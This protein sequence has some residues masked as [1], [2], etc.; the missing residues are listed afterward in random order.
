MP[1]FVVAAIIADAE[2]RL[3]VGQRPP[4]KKLAGYWEFPGGKVEA[5]ETPEMAVIRELKEELGITVEPVRRL[6][7]VEQADANGHL[8]LLP[9]ECEI[10]CGTPVALEH[11]E[12]RWSMPSELKPLKMAP[13]DRPVLTN[14][15]RSLPDFTL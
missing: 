9:I 3:L 12:I 11:T 10:V 6:P 2:G 14:Y 13:A 4:G 15:L 5:G 1:I 7:M 8:E